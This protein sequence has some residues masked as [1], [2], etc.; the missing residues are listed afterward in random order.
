MLHKKDFVVHSY[1]FPVPPHFLFPRSKFTFISTASESLNS[2]DQFKMRFSAIHVV[3]LGL[4]PEFSTAQGAAS[5]Q[6][7]LTIPPCETL[8]SIVESCESKLIDDNTITASVSSCLCHDGS[9]NYAP[10]I[11]DN[12]VA[13]CSSALPEDS[14][15]FGFWIPGLCTGAL[16]TGTG[17]AST[18]TVVS[19]TNPLS[20][21]TG[22]GTVTVTNGVIDT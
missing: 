17:A 14:T 6:N 20:G 12:A 16:A 21:F 5:T 22:L 13:G 15:D 10:T 1:L 2:R 18:T 9:G 11:Y 19:T 3:L 8:L 7:P 4:L